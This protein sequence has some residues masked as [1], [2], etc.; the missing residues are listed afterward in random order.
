MGNLI[1]H[2]F[3]LKILFQEVKEHRLSEKLK[4]N[5]FNFKT[6]QILLL[7][8]KEKKFQKLLLLNKNFKK[9]MNFTNN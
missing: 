3:Y 1:N 6:I 8:Q 9:I 5:L 4:R 7:Y 2:K